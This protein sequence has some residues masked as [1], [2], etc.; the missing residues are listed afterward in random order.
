MTARSVCA[1]VMAGGKGTRMAL[2]QEKPL[3]L[4]K[5]KPVVEHVVSALKN[6]K[7]VNRVVVAVTSCTPK[8]ARFLKKHGVEVLLTPGKE[9][10]S[11]LAFAVKQLGLGVVLAVAADLPLLT[12]DV[13]DEVVEAYFRVGKPALAV[14]VPLETK[15]KLGMSLGY[16]FVHEDVQV[17]P[18][19]INVNDGTRI[20]EEWID[21]AV[22]LVDKAEVAV[23]I[24]TVEEL[25]VARR[26]F[27][28]WVK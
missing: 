16:A 7:S 24:N 28:K 2:A 21:Q 4:V 10:V 13:V 5:G 22:Y 27:S 18:A 6:A 1:V 20:N 3:L 19:G 23:N 25:R 15:R 26:Q 8:T 9:Y 11:D 17:V 14:A 12:C